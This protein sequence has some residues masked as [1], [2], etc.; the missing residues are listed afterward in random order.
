MEAQKNRFSLICICL[1]NKGRR[2]RKCK[3]ITKWSTQVPYCSRICLSLELRLAHPRASLN[4]H[5]LYLDF[6]R[7]Y[8][9]SFPRISGITQL[10]RCSQTW[11]HQVK[12]RKSIQ[13]SSSINGVPR[14]RKQKMSFSSGAYLATLNTN[15]TI[16]FLFSQHLKGLEGIK[17]HPNN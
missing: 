11:S 10:F 13:E 4:N 8:I 2:G 9:F 5:V 7:E 15:K 16:S 6:L 17:Q 3:N 14:L 1:S 12:F